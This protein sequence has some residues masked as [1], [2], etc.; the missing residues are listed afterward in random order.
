MLKG[1]LEPVN[2]FSLGLVTQVNRSRHTRAGGGSYGNKV[3]KDAAR[4]SS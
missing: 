3:P 2:L 1:S 4:L